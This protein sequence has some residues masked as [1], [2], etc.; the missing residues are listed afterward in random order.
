MIED[1]DPG[2]DREKTEEQLNEWGAS[3]IEECNEDLTDQQLPAFV[4]TAG[5]MVAFLCLLPPVIIFRMAGMTND[6]PRMHIVP[7]MD[8]QHKNKT[9]TVSPN[10]AKKG[11]PLY[12]FA[13]GRA[14]RPPIEGT[15]AWG[16]LADDPEYYQG[17]QA[18]SA[19]VTA[20][21]KKEVLTSI[22]DD[23]EETD[24]AAPAAEKEPNWITTFPKHLTE[25][26]DFDPEQLLARGKARFE[27]YCSVCHGYSGNGDG[28]VNQRAMALGGDR[29]SRLD[30]CQIVARSGS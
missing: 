2:F 17:I 28:L 30:D 11:D 9:Q 25:Q 6:A 10:F 27:I 20:T 23:E 24:A 5:I 13:D 3:F 1:A 26:E 12:L 29:K 15:I 21:A 18:G 19:E 16:Q 22:N 8:W 4:R 7:D 14:M